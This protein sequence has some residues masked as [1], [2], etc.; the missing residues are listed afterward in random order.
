MLARTDVELVG[1]GSDH[2]A[3]EFFSVR[4]DSQIMRNMVLDLQG[5][6]TMPDWRDAIDNY[7]H[8]EFAELI[9]PRISVA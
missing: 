3:E 5:M 6:N 2:F 7:V 4:P 9:N 8:A 1:V